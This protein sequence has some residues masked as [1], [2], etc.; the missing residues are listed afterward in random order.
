MEYDDSFKKIINEINNTPI[1]ELTKMLKENDVKFQS[2][3]LTDGKWSFNGKEWSNE[4]NKCC[5]DCQELCDEYCEKVFI[6]EYLLCEG[7]KYGI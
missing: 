6:D 5:Y 3:I 4:C 1:D 7:C 2:D